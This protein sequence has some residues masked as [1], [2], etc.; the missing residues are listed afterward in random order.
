MKQILVL[1]SI[2]IAGIGFASGQ[3]STGKILGQVTDTT[4]ALIPGVK[5][6]LTSSAILQPIVV[7]TSA[8]GTYQFS[9]IPSGTLFVQFDAV[10]SIVPACTI[11][12]ASIS[13]L[14][15]RSM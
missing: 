4:G 3:T 10:F 9:E 11:T 6:T 14:T 5:V 12:S 1:L 13:D 7:T 2:L 8:A 15:P